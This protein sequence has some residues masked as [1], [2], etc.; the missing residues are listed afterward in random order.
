MEDVILGNPEY[1]IIRVTQLPVIEQ[2]LANIADTFTACRE[3]AVRT[4]ATEENLAA[5]KSSRA[6]MRKQFDELETARKGVKEKIAEPYK[7]FEE[8]YKRIVT[9]AFN[10]ADAEFKAKIDAVDENRRKEKAETARK[11]FDEYAK[12]V[13]IDDLV[14]LDTLPVKFNVSSSDASILKAIQTECDRIA[15]DK[16]AALQME[17]GMEILY[18]YKA[19]HNLAEAI[20]AVRAR[21]QF[22]G[23]PKPDTPTTDWKPAEPEIHAPEKV[24]TLA[25]SVTGTMAQLKALK[26]YITNS[27]LTAN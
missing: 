18:E 7:A 23:E 21:H 2:H 17:H 3:L 15:A 14:T 1:P 25:F 4:A 12:A 5:L 26:E 6:T 13:G 22:T 10:E 8:V 9:D 24:Y 16:K 19:H 11:F 27:G 20:E